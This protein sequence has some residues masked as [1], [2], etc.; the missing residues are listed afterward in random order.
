MVI[1][2]QRQVSLLHTPPLPENSCIGYL[3][4]KAGYR[5]ALLRALL[6]ALPPHNKQHNNEKHRIILLFLYF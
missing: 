4:T 5:S 3:N 6:R 2:I 1:E